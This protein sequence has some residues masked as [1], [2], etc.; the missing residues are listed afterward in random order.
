MPEWLVRRALAT[1]P[2][3]LAVVGINAGRSLLALGL[4]TG[5]PATAQA[6]DPIVYH[7]VSPADPWT[8]KASAVFR[9]YQNDVHNTIFEFRKPQPI[10]G[11]RNYVA[12]VR[13]DDATYVQIRTEKGKILFEEQSFAWSTRSTTTED[14]Y[15]VMD[16]DTLRDGK[17]DGNIP[18]EMHP[19]S[20]YD[21]SYWLV[22]VKNDSARRFY[23]VFDNS[24]LTAPRDKQVM[25]AVNE[26]L[27]SDAEQVIA[28][29]LSEHGADM[30]AESCQP[31][32]SKTG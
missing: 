32:M 2:G 19:N 23:C 4:A 21:F 10:A 12:E 13:T 9:T 11:S 5:L 26:N 3:L 7:F 16:T 31:D 22:L 14:R 20:A 8:I 25:N 29:F 15:Y 27:G 30:Q 28:R 24:R 17:M 18:E 1:Q 6:R